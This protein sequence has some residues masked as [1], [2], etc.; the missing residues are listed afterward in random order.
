MREL[1]INGLRISQFGG[2]GFFGGQQAA[3][4]GLT[5]STGTRTLAELA[6]FAC[7]FKRVNLGHVS[8]ALNLDEVLGHTSELEELKLSSDAGLL[9]DDA[10][11]KLIVNNASTLS[12]VAAI[13]VG[14]KEP[15]VA[16]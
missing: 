16:L 14:K 9:D 3:N 2:F 7:F 12:S 15:L 13:G 11:T 10:V 4:Q 5:L 8:K 6:R 1:T